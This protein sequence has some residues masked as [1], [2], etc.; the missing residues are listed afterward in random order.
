VSNKMRARQHSGY[1]QW[2]SRRRMAAA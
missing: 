2:H 1:R